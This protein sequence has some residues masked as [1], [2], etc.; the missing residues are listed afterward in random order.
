MHSFDTKVKL[1]LTLKLNY[2]NLSFQVSSVYNEYLL[3]HNFQQGL[4]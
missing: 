3:I 4:F 2:K 1:L